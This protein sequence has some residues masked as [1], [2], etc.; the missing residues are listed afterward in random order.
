LLKRLKTSSA[1][2]LAKVILKTN[3]NDW[4]FENKKDDFWVKGGKK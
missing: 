1:K 4:W 3:Y 2:Q